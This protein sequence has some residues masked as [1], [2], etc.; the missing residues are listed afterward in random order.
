[1]RIV[2]A[3]PARSG[4]P[5]LADSRVGHPAHAEIVVER[6]RSCGAGYPVSSQRCP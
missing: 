3:L 2:L 4:I 5:L 1:M 6:T